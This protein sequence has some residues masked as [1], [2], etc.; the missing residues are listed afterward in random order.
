MIVLLCI[1]FTGVYGELC[2]FAHC[3]SECFGPCEYHMDI[4]NK[5]CSAGGRAGHLVWQKTLGL[6]IIIVMNTDA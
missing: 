3:D 1:L 6:D 4:C 5:S 2:N